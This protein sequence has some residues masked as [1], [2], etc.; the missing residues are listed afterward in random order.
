MVDFGG[1]QVRLFRYDDEWMA[2]ILGFPNSLI[3]A[4]GD[5]PE[6]AIAELRIAYQLAIEVLEDEG[7]PVPTPAEIAA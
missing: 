4:G 1:F 6:E 5:T 7:I 2:E 3:S